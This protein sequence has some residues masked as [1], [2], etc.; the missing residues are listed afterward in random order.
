MSDDTSYIDRIV[1]YIKSVIPAPEP[2][3]HIPAYDY[4]F[5]NHQGYTHLKMF[6]SP[7]GVDQDLI[8]CNFCGKF[9]AK[10]SVDTAIEHVKGH[11]EHT[12]RRPNSLGLGKLGDGD[13]SG[14]KGEEI[15]IFAGHLTQREIDERKR[16][17]RPVGSHLSLEDK[18]QND[19]WTVEKQGER[20][21]NK[22][23]LQEQVPDD[24]TDPTLEELDSEK[25][26][27]ITY[28]TEFGSSPDEQRE[29]GDD[30]L[31]NVTPRGQQNRPTTSYEVELE[32]I[33]EQ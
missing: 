1:Q 22:S 19:N 7:D 21:M 20:V 29:N 3:S 15:D 12:F 14:G 26:K 6:M 23:E 33:H 4:D 31:L 8:R 16:S 30:V 9:F 18:Q 17:T 10:D 5:L 27:R 13:S 25:V 24:E 32:E 28:K 11:R 2:E